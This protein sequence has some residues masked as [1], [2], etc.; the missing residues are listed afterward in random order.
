MERDW[1]Q[2]QVPEIIWGIA[3]D[4]SEVLTKALTAQTRSD[5]WSEAISYLEN[6]FVEDNGSKKYPYFQTQQ[7][8]APFYVFNFFQKNQKTLL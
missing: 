4:L 3:F 6:I 2:K 8:M 7:D 5:L 1:S